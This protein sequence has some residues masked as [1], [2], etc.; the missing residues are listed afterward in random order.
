MQ[1]YSA[2]IC[3]VAVVLAVFW[4]LSGPHRSGTLAMWAIGAG[5]AGLICLYASIAY[6]RAFT[7]CTPAGLRTR[8]LAGTR[9]CPWAEVRTIAPRVYRQTTTV[10]VTTV[11]G[12]RFRLG[13]PVTGGV[14][15]DPEFGQRAEQIWQYWQRASQAA[16]PGTAGPLAAGN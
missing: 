9:T 10:M 7:E 15:S 6:A 14:M 3:G 4:A 11:H 1:L 8:G 12:T 16:G 2:G 13:V 5:V